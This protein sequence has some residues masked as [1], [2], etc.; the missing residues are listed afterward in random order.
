MRTM[1]ILAAVDGSEF[2][3]NAIEF[4]ASRQTLI[5]SGLDLQILNVQLRLP[6]R[7]A[8][9]VGKE[10]VR[11]YYADE[12]EKILKPVRS[13][14]DKAGLRPTVRYAVGHPASE[15][16]VAAQKAAVD[17]VVLGSHG[18]SA[19]AGLL[20][21]SVTTEVLARTETAMLIVR[22]KEKA[23]SD[24]LKVGI[25]IDGSAYG[26][27]AVRYVLR[28][29]ALFGSRP[30]ISLIHVVHTYD[31]VGMP[32]A[33]GIAPPAFSPTEVRA[34]QDKAFEAAMGPVRKLFKDKGAAVVD[35]VRLSG[36]P[37][38]ELTAYAKKKL[39]LLVIGSHGYGAFKAAV[40]GSVA[41]RVAA[42]GSSP[43]LLIR[44][45]SE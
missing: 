13:R 42:Q 19:L 23:Y 25:A 18:R 20:L 16:S 33:A 45:S 38:D 39:D 28:H 24:S 1:K 2:T 3:R 5:N 26:P 34:M 4:L 14:L 21:G 27:A 12:A 6:A 36:S 37:G 32:S 17:L 30:S 41:T 31:L 35:E 44:R 11:A 9:I 15:I 8:R 43:L 22:G 10:V 7:P 40:M 29:K